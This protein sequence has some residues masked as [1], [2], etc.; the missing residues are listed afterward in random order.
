MM[1]GK[2][3]EWKRKNK[4]GMNWWSKEMSEKKAEKRREMRWW[5]KGKWGKEREKWREGRKKLEENG[6]WCKENQ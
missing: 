5:K 3:K 4:K 1:K 2:N 6:K